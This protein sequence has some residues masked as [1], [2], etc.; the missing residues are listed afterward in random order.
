MG[1]VR[2]E[3]LQETGGGLYPEVTK[4]THIREIGSG[5]IGVNLTAMPPCKGVHSE[6]FQK[7]CVQQTKPSC[8][9]EGALVALLG[10]WTIASMSAFG[11]GAARTTQGREGHSRCRLQPG[12]Q[13]NWEDKDG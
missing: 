4:L 13:G 6:N 12:R 3:L 11:I 9:P 5:G 8:G 10:T 1:P 7:C 2:A